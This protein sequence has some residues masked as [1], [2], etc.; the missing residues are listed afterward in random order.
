MRGG[1]YAHR[2]AHSGYQ[3]AGTSVICKSHTN[4]II[5]KDNDQSKPS[6]P[7]TNDIRSPAW[8]SLTGLLGYLRI[9]R[10]NRFILY[11]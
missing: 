10:A 8:I 1:C 2:C 4:S 7:A 11:K 3:A 5:F 6:L 9:R